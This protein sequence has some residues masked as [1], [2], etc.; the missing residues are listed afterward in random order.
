MAA[1]KD[2]G[3]EPTK[4]QSKTDIDEL[5]A[6]LDIGKPTSAF[7]RVVLEN[8]LLGF[9][10][11]GGPISSSDGIYIFRPTEESNDRATRIRRW[12]YDNAPNEI[13]GSKERYQ[14]R[15]TTSNWRNSGIL[16][17]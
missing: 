9:Q 14:N 10:I 5:Q 13:W 7:V 6:Y 1:S 4:S 8:N 15:I 3:L 16:D 12:M 17:K 2:E 11:F